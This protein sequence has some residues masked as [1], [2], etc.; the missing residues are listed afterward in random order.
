VSDA[1]PHTYPTSCD[2]NTSSRNSNT[3]TNAIT[4][5]NRILIAVSLLLSVGCS[6]VSKKAPPPSQVSVPVMAETADVAPVNKGV[7]NVQASVDRTYQSVKSLETRLSRVSED[8][9]AA[10][11][12][13]EFA[14]STGMAAR[15][16]EAE[17]MREQVDRVVA[18]VEKTRMERDLMDK[19]VNSTKE[20]LVGVVSELGKVQVSLTKMESEAVNLRSNLADANIRLDT[21]A[22]QV[23][24]LQTEVAKSAQIIESKST[25][26][27]RWMVAFLLL[28][29]INA[30]Y[31]A[32][33]LQ[34]WSILSRF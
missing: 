3:S 14:F 8:A 26:M 30:V 29:T 15:S 9:R 34:G 21:G 19:E 12:S 25:W 4:M 28:L 1:H 31:V 13:A 23:T 5:M 2:P 10:K 24:A 11:S 20:Q 22:K 27:K 33:R 18:E 16:R 6:S 32:G 17:I 7:G